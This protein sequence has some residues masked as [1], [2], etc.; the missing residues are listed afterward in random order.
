MHW[1]QGCGHEQMFH[2]MKSDGA[3]AMCDDD[4]D[5]DD[6]DAVSRAT[7]RST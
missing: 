1:C 4:D 6:D 3:L 5:D 7:E 2:V